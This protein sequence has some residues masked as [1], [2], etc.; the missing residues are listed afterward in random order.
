[1][2]SSSLCHT[3]IISHLEFCVCDAS[4]RREVF[5]KPPS[6]CTIPE[7]HWEYDAIHC[8]FMFCGEIF[9]EVHSLFKSAKGL[10]S[11]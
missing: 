11:I 9:V 8:P 1:M 7:D 6:F 10:G 4:Y 5:M 3:A 2:S